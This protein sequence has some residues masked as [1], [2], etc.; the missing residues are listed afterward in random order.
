[1]RFGIIGC[2]TI[3]QIMHLP[4][5]AEI[6]ETEL[7]ALVDPASDRTET[8]GNWYGID[9][10]FESTDAMLDEISDDLD[11]VI[12]ST[13]P[14]QHAD[15]VEQVLD[16]NISTLVEKPLAVSVEDA[17]QM[18]AAAERSEATAMVGYMRRYD[19]MYETAE[20][21]IS[22]L[23]QIDLIS[24]YDVDPDHGR[25]IDEVYDIVG[26]DV[27]DELIEE[28]MW[29]QRSDSMQVIDSENE[30]RADDYH[31]HLEHIC[32]D[33][34]VLRGLFG[35]VECIDHVDIYADGRYATAHLVYEG[36]IRCTLD[37]GLSDRKW[38][39]ASLRV[40][41]PNGMV[42][43]E[44][45]NSFIKN[46]PTE[47]QVKQG[48]EQ[49]TDETQT[50][51]YAESFKRE[52]EHFAGCVQGEREVRTPFTEARDDVRLIADLFRHDDGASLIGEY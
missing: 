5:V 27:P 51:S 14:N 32:H 43:L 52:I 48:T 34:N 44:W 16:A 26:G 8:L 39:E 50:P 46:T 41:T 42:R 49:L 12:V 22:N 28:G 40:D 6:P 18:V 15:V 7:Y 11:A 33:I 37:S 17:D 9:H 36:G 24:A 23:D 2:G 45:D 1:M 47:L 29:K 30:V 19:P 4:Y 31:W 20:E 13:P 25:I 10:R 38:F 35:D 3:A 21:E